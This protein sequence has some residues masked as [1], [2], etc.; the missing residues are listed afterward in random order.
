[1]ALVADLAFPERLTGLNRLL[2]PR[3]V[4]VIGASDDPTR[5]GGRPLRYLR[6]AGYAG[7][8]FAVNHRG[9]TVQGIAAF[10]SI[11]ALPE[12]PDVA[13][14]AVPAS[15]TPTTVAQC[16]D[17]GVSVAIVL[18]A[19][20]A[21]TGPD[22]VAVQNAMRARAAAAG[23]RL[24]GPNC[25]GA[26]NS[27]T[28]FYGTFANALD[29]RLPEPGPVAVVSQSGAYG[30]HLGYLLD[31][32]G[33]GV[34]YSV[35]TGNEAD[36]DVADVLTWMALRPEVEVIL[37][38]VEGV[39]D[40][41]RF[42]EALRVAH[43]AG[44]PVVMLKVGTSEAGERA[45]GTHTAALAGADRVFD[46]VFAQYGVHRATSTQEQVDVGYTLARTRRTTGDRLGIVTVS[47][48]AGVQ[49]CDAAE[50]HG[51]TVPTL[52][53]ATRESITARLSYASA[54]NP[55]D[56][57]AQA[58]LDTDMLAHALRATVESGDIDWLVAF[59][60]TT[61]LARPFTEPLRRAIEN[62]T[63]GR[64]D[65]PVALVMLADPEVVRDYEDHG[66]LVFDDT[67]RTV[68][69]LAAA[70]RLGRALE[71]P[72]PPVHR[73]AATDRPALPGHPLN[74]YE[75]A[76]LLAAAGLPMLP[77][78]LVTSTDEALAVAGEIGFPVAVKICSA[79][80]VHKTDIGGV[81]L[82]VADAQQL[83][84]AYDTVL[85]GAAR[86]APGARIDGV[87]VSP[88]APAGIETVVGVHRD[89]LFGPVVM[90]GL[91]GIL[92]EVLGDVAF[93]LAPFDEAEATRMV[94][95][96]TGRAV[97]AGVRGGPAADTVALARS[98]ATIS[99]FAAAH[100]DELVAVDLNPFL[101][102]PHGAVA[103]DAV[104]VTGGQS[105]SAGDS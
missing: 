51:M 98:L 13:L 103:L 24:L 81:V 49:L 19:G 54:T 39:G 30:A 84:G 92:V 95:E 96:L 63:G 79:D 90:V 52:N 89:P 21:E 82:E 20:F 58:L 69:A 104:V 22:G 43:E 8:I 14:L 91:G 65:R 85:A 68:R 66:F 77:Q 62:G 70:A 27:G 47:G 25:L 46:A 72:T 18:S 100:T 74:E 28:G 31:Q 5:I 56:V 57:T 101:V 73:V 42:R 37:A 45:A 35:T 10:T 67:E 23:M 102:L 86:A 34:R 55:V 76:R 87:L 12:V 3:S 59:F 99:R 6:E 60:T 105:R 97:L 78:R 26:Y 40:G 64:G 75:S 38:Y 11:A 36:I 15:A 61:A 44:T 9:G 29:R 41:T 83:R 33:I 93:R 80:I 94:D 4:A 2:D 16:A 88:M 1:M 48:G 32:R 53:A 7:G 71:R 17:A 50:R